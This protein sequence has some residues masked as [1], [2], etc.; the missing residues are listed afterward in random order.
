MPD[1]IHTTW[2]LPENDTNYS[3]RWRLIKHYVAI[4]I[5]DQ[6]TRRGEQ[7]IWQ[8]RFWE[9]MIRDDVDWQRHLDYIHYNPGKHGYVQRLIDRDLGFFSKAIRQG[10]YE[11]QWGSSVPT[12]LN[13]MDL[14]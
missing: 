3:L 11:K 2:Q 1:H 13:G 5:G 7:K 4:S 14:E 10:W 9:H 12:E 6:S 8:R